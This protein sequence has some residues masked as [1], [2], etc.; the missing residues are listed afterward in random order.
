MPADP[1][2]GAKL[3]LYETF[4]RVGKAL[5]SPL[6]LILLDLLGQA[7]R[8]VEELAGQAG[9]QVANTSAQLQVLR[10]AGLVATR[11]E[12]TRVYYRL[13]SGQ[14]AGLVA[15]LREVARAELAE[16]DR[17][18]RE[19]LGDLSGMEPV[20]RDELARR[21]AEG[22]V[23]VLDVRPAAEYA[24]GHV[25]GARSVPLEQLEARLAELPADAG[26]VAYCRGRYCVYA[27]E[28]VRLLRARGYQADRLE[29]GFDEWRRAGGEIEVAGET[30]VP[31][32]IRVADKAEVAMEPGAAGEAGTAGEHPGG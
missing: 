22:S 26:I 10:A 28:A 14:V 21:L 15:Q 11:K 19:Y 4:A 2:S 31:G 9:A 5:A 30:R 18:A 25:P 27:P 17:A 1:K 23:V 32:E 16:A 8:S 3:A 20:S 7:E 12:G 6:R 13:A 24:A 29:D